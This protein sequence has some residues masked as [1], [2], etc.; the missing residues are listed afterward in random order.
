[1]GLPEG[2]Q[3]EVVETSSAAEEPKNQKVETPRIAEVPNEASVPAEAVVSAKVQK[4][5]GVAITKVFPLRREPGQPGFFGPTEE[6]YN[7]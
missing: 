4:D 7:K 5:V 1:M 6:I 2:S 3:A